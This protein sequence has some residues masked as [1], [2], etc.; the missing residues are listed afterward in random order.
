MATTDPTALNKLIDNRATLQ[1]AAVDSSAAPL[2]F[3]VKAFDLPGIDLGAAV[4]PTPL[5]DRNLPGTKLKY[6]SV[7]LTFH[8]DEDLK[9]WLAVHDW[10]RGLAPPDETAF[11]IE[12]KLDKETG[13]LTILSSHNNPTFRVKL[14]EMWP[15]FLSGLSFT[16]ADPDA[17]FMTAEARFSI[18]RYDI[19]KL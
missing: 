1:V 4:Q 14:Y 11:Y 6:E 12:R 19:E 10:M 8:I 15:T 3:N 5:T 2:N 16:F 18:L 7:R 9:S 17:T 13:I